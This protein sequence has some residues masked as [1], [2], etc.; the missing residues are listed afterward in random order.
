MEGVH[1]S[2]LSRFPIALVFSLITYTFVLFPLEAAQ[3]NYR[4]IKWSVV[5]RRPKLCN[6]VAP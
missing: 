4:S 6:T 2:S 3:K 1:F 5:Q